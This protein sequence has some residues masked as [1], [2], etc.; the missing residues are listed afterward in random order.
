MQQKKT[1]IFLV[2]ALLLSIL[3]TGGCAKS[4]STSTN[5]GADKAVVD[6]LS[7]KTDAIIGVL[8]KFAIPMREYGQRY[9]N[10]YYAAKSGNWA[11]AAYMLNYMKGAMKPASVTKPDEY[12]TLQGWQKSNFSPLVDAME[13]KD[14]TNFEKAYNDTIAACNSCHAGLGYPFVV[15]KLP[16]QPFDMHLDYTKATEPTDFK[17]FSTL[18]Q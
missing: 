1:V 17:E 7:K 5:T 16:S 14:F 18:K 9:A 13:K 2:G 4:P 11:L 3:I 12:N 10:M 8:P 6:D 15:Y